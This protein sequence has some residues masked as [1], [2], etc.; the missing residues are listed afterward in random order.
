MFE[1]ELW[2]SYG[3]ESERTTTVS[4]RNVAF[5][6]TELENSNTLKINHNRRFFFEKLSAFVS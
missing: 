6:Y 2:V 1:E 4:Q 3:Y 5:S